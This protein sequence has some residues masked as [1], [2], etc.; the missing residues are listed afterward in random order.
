MTKFILHGGGDLFGQKLKKIL[1]EIIQN[2]SVKKVKILVI[3][4]ARK[5][6]EWE[7]VY[8][9]YCKRYSRLSLEKE[10]ILA[11]QDINSLKLQISSSDI[12]FL[13]G[14]SELLI[15]KYLKG[16]KSS[17]FNNKIIIGV[18]AGANILSSYYYSNDRNR[19]E[20]G[21][22]ILPIKTICHFNLSKNKKLK[23][24]VSYKNKQQK[25][26]FPIKEGDFIV[27]FV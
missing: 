15:K 18:S 23:K 7:D 12:I 10:F 22:G 13:C 25:I 21:L 19:I 4:F 16:I 3:P 5:K 8:I 26:T 27:L 17:L 24:L 9:K 20:K 1:T 14:G 2:I 11:S 6:N